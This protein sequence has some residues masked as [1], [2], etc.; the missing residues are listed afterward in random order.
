LRIGQPQV[1]QYNVNLTL[2]EMLLS[3]THALRVYQ[4]DLLRDLLVEHLAEQTSVTG[5][6]FDYEKHFD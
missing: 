1:E 6:I 3:L 5:V 2:G 4:L